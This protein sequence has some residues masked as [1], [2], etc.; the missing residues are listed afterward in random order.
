MQFPDA[1]RHGG[2]QRA[3]NGGTSALNGTTDEEL[4]CDEFAFNAT[5]N[6]GGMPSLAGGLNP[7][8]SG[9]ACVQTLASKQGSTVHL[10]NIDGH[11]PT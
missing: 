8:G 4:N 2:R 7:V 10:F 9:D 3:A 5:Y 11:A 6:S 1:G